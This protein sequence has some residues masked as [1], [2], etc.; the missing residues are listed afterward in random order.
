[1]ACNMEGEIDSEATDICNLFQ[2]RIYLLIRRYR[3][4]FF[5]ASQRTMAF[6]FVYDCINR[7]EQWHPLRDACLLHGLGEPLF[8][9]RA[10]FEVNLRRLWYRGELGHQNQKYFMPPQMHPFHIIGLIQFE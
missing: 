7:G 1:M 10:V 8:P 4:Q 3:Q 2:L 6:V 9:I 5:F